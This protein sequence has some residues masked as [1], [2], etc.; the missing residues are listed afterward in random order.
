MKQDNEVLLR[1]TRKGS[2][3]QVLIFFTMWLPLLFGMSALVIDFGFIYLYNNELNASTQSAA[4]A[5]AYAMSQPGAT[6][7]STTTAI[8]AYTGGTGDTNNASNLKGAS[9]ATGYPLFKCLNTLT[10]AFG[11]QCYGPSNSNAIVVTQ[12]VK[13]PLLFFRLFGG[14]SATLTATAT[15][16]M[17]GAIVEPWNVV[18]IV[19]STNSMTQ[20]DSDSNC[21]NSRISCAL[22]GVRVLLGGIAPCPASEASCG[23][24]TSGNVVNSVDRVSLFTFPPVTTVTAPNDYNCSGNAPA[25]VPY[26]YP[27]L[28]AADTYQIVGF[29]SD[30]R[31]S[32]SAASLNTGSNL[33]A[34]IGGKSGCSGLQAIG[35]DGTYYGQ[36]IRTA[37]ASLVAQQAANPNSQNVL[38]ILSDGNATALAAKMTGSSATSG[39][40]M[41]TIQECHQAVTEAKAAAAAGTRV[42]TVAYGA[43]ASGCTYDTVAHGGLITPCQTMQQMASS[44]AYFFSDYTATGGDSTC[45]SASQPVTSLSGIFQVIVGDLTGAKLVPN[46]TT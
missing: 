32:A 29:S 8:T 23:S 7:Q 38:V 46:G 43:E 6:V 3:G 25:I 17:K 15:A 16:S 24:A 42:Y 44:P 12:Q 33:V 35:G 34:A 9:L 10:S 31:T 40:Y 14:T 21:N 27:T 41:S 5:G 45:I 2:R 1:R 11:L 26:V 13:V 4:L 37:Q 22:A 19:D 30:Y 39:T 28:P 36:V 20:P 18:V